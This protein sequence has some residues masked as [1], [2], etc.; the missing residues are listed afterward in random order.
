MSASYEA[1]AKRAADRCEYCHVP[2]AIFTLRFEVDHICTDQPG[3]RRNTAQ[4][5]PCLSGLQPLEIQCNLWSR[6]IDCPNN[7]FAKNDVKRVI[8]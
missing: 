8:V 2:E 4:S 3:R 5:R 7:T 1:V 6:L